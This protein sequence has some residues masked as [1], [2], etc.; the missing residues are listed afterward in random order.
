MQQDE[1]LIS[2]QVRAL[3]DERSLSGSELA[4]RIGASQSYVS[5]RLR[6]EV[7]WRASD[8]GRIA[9]VVNVP[10]ADLVDPARTTA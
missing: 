8:L 3:L 1:A 6:G 5:R 2:T 10:V 7:P 4:R 9:K